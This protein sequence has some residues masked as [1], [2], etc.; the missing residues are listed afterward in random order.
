M[1]PAGR[2]CIKFIGPH[3]PY[4]KSGGRFTISLDV[5]GF[6][7]RVIARLVSR[8]IESARFP[9][10]SDDEVISARRGFRRIGGTTIPG[11]A[12]RQPY[13]GED[14]QAAERGPKARSFA[15]RRPEQHETG[16]PKSTGGGAEAQ[17]AAALS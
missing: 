8:R 14:E 3:K 5:W 9:R 11:F 2:A 7:R 17:P 16:P 13:R 4:R 6:G 10:F 15:P 12:T 1:A